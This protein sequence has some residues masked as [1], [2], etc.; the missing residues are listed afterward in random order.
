[1]DFPNVRINNQILYVHSLSR[2][3]AER[4]FVPADRVFPYLIPAFI[5]RNCSFLL[6][7][8]QKKRRYTLVL[9]K[10]L[11]KPELCPV[12]MPDAAPGEASPP[13]PDCLVGFLRVDLSVKER[14]P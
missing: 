7:R 8:R 14:R 13:L 2:T 5:K 3:E 9:F 12:A 1:M 4:L 6:R 10:L 11:G